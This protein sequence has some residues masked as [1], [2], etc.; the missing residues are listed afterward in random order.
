MQQDP[1]VVKVWSLPSTTRSISKNKRSFVLCSLQ[2]D[3]TIFYSCCI[4]LRPAWVRVKMDLQKKHLSSEANASKKKNHEQGMKEIQGHVVQSPLLAKS[5]RLWLLT[6]VYHLNM[7]W[8]GVCFQVP[9]PTQVPY[10]S[11]GVFRVQT[12]THP[13]ECE[14][15]IVIGMA[16]CGWGYNLDHNFIFGGILWIFHNLLTE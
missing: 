11:F 13:C 6:G 1:S 7:V 12:G 3:P 2:R 8:S 9:V 10:T 14:W 15:W 5:F 16:F 4:H